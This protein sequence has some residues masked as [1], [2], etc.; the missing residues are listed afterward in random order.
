MLT[1]FS[2]KDPKSTSNNELVRVSEITEIQQRCQPFRDI[3]YCSIFKDIFSKIKDTKSTKNKFYCPTGGS[4]RLLSSKEDLF[5]HLYRNHKLSVTQYYSS[6]GD[7]ISLNFCD[8]S[9]V[10][11]VLPKSSDYLFFVKFIKNIDEEIF[12]VWHLIEGC[13]MDES[14]YKIK[15]KDSKNNKILWEGKPILMKYSF[16]EIYNLGEYFS[17]NYSVKNL[18]VKILIK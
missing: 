11:V 16:N 15:F 6:V 8:K 14:K 18:N 2:L 12:L 7:N 9:V 10:C 17:C 1:K 13:L 4:C 5:T 3:N